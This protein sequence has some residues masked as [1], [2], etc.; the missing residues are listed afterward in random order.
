MTVKE[1]LQQIQPE[2]LE[3]EIGVICDVNDRMNYKRGVIDL[4][5]EKGSKRIVLSEIS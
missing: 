5:L 2:D 4:K 3:K 1:F